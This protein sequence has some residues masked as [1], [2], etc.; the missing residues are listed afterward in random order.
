MSSSD[1]KY[2]GQRFW[3]QGS[4]LT[5]FGIWILDFGFKRQSTAIPFPETLRFCGSLFDYAESHPRGLKFLVPLKGVSVQVSA[6]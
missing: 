3:V 2:G 1:I 6:C 5:D 4:G